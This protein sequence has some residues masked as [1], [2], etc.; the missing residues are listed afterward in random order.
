MDAKTLRDTVIKPKLVELLGG[1][2]G[3]AVLTTGLSASMKGKTDSEKAHLMVEAVCADKKL[4]GMMGA[5]RA[6]QQKNEWLKLA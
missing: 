4:V 5:A 2:L 1:N 6:Q 3:L